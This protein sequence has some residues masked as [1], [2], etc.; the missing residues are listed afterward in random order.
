MKKGECSFY[1]TSVSF[2][3]PFLSISTEII[4]E[5]NVIVTTGAA[6][7]HGHSK[8]LFLVSKSFMIGVHLIYIILE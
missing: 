4:V 1:W 2:H 8:I 3:R 5:T 6:L 7:I